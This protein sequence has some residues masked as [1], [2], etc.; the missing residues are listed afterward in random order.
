MAWRRISCRIS[1]PYFL[2]LM[3]PGNLISQGVRIKIGNVLEHED[4]Y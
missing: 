1:E 3:V 4:V 2:S